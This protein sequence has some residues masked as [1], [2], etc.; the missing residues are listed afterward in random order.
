M[1]THEEIH[2]FLLFRSMM[3]GHGESPFLVHDNYIRLDGAICD[4]VLTWINLILRHN[5]FQ[6][7]L[8]KTFD[9]IIVNSG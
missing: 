2:A 3:I 1:K 8:F 5:D 9:K 6:L 4:K 7:Y